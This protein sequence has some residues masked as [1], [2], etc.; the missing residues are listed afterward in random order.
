M[1]A[2]IR[3][4]GKQYKV[5]EGDRIRVELIDVDPGTPIRFNHVL[6]LRKKDTVEIGKP[7]VE[8]ASVDAMVAGHGRGRKIV[9]FKHKR[10]KGYRRKAGHRQDFT[11]LRITAI[12]NGQ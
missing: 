6:M 8:G 11:E 10:R 2:I 1:Y 3:T 5:Q 4:G 9:V 12:R 7:F